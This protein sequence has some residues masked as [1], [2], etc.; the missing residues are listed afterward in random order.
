MIISHKYKYIFLKTTKTAG[1]SVEIALS[2]FCGPE[3]VITPILPEDE[4]LRLEVGGR[5]PQNY[6]TPFLEYPMRELPAYLLKGFRRQ[7]FYNHIPA[8]EI[9]A[10]L[11]SQIWKS[12]T[13]FCIER[14]PWDRMVS[15]YF[16]MYKSEPRPSFT[17]FVNSPA[18]FVLKNEGFGVY[19]IKGKIAVDKVCQ[20]EHLTDEMEAMRT[21]LGIPE[22]LT[23]PHAKA[24]FR[25][26]KKDYHDLYGE[27]E[28]QRIAEIFREEIALFGYQF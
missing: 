15:Q 4:T 21:Q 7:K 6:W 1:T 14:N 12:Y 23:L 10:L 2:K 24:S 16:W 20:F 3:D 17:E 8:V 22:A 13:K 27:I 18:P 9:R 26:A 25:G 5:A 11:R 28:K 19:S